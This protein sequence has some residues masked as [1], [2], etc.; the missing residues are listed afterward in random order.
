MRRRT[1]NAERTEQQRSGQ[2]DQRPLDHRPDPGVGTHPGD[3]DDHQHEERQ[4]E[5]EQPDDADQPTTPAR[6]IEAKSRETPHARPIA[7]SGR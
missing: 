4:V 3:E 7:S 6:E 5:T 1:L 2:R